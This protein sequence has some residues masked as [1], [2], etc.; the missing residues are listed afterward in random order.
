V[1]LGGILKAQKGGQDRILP[2]LGKWVEVRQ[3][4]AIIGTTHWHHC[5]Y[6]TGNSLY[7]SR[8]QPQNML[9]SRSSNGDWPLTQPAG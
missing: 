1:G 6:Y 8:P 2:N 3:G 9:L 4:E 5:G 7:Y